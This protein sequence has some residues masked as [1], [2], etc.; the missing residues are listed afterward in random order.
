MAR[1]DV[2]Q[3]LT[4]AGHDAPAATLIGEACMARRVKTS[5]LIIDDRDADAATLT[6]SLHVLRPW[7]MT[8]SIIGS[9]EYVDEI[10]HALGG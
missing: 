7:V 4:T 8:L 9:A 3:M 5:G 2:V 6:R 10:L 1:F